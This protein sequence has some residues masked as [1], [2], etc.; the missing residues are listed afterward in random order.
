M[1][2]TF[3]NITH[4]LL[5]QGLITKK[6]IFN[7]NLTITPLESRNNSFTIQ[8]EGE[9]DF[10]LKQVKALDQER[11]STLKTEADCYWLAENHRN[12]SELA[13]HIPTYVNYDYTNHILVT[14]CLS[15]TVNLSQFYMAEKKMPLEVAAQQADTLASCHKQTKATDLEENVVRLFPNY[16]PSVFALNEQNLEY[17]NEKDKAAE[18]MVKLIRGN[19]KFLELVQ[20]AGQDWQSSTLIHGDVKHANYLIREEGKG[21]QT[22]LIDWEIASFGDPCWDVAGVLQNYL[23]YWIDNE[24]N[25]QQHSYQ[26]FDLETLKPSLQSFWQN[27]SQK[28]NYTPTEA[29]KALEKSLRFSGLKLIQT[30]RE[31]LREQRQMPT[32]SAMMLQLSLNILSNP[33][34]SA[35][36]LIL[37]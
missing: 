23:L 16:R 20:S 19:K 34:Q 27:Y 8:R 25:G 21:Y 26:G 31:S 14:E 37:N 29:E 11:T 17:W 36:Q 28:M 5:D 32:S 2:L 6:D 15:D 18:Q 24:T 12:F 13:A 35:E 10:F 3:R 7:N 9:M 30:C 4:Y 22:Y 1:F 33:K